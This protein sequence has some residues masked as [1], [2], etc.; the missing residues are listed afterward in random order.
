MIN[1]SSL[2]LRYLK[3]RK[4]SVEHFN[5]LLVNCACCWVEEDDPRQIAKKETIA[6]FSD[7]FVTL[8]SNP[9]YY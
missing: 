7:P 5:K 6:T 2:F 4:N 8:T 3:V 1:S 9:A